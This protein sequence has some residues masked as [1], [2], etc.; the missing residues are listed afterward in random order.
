MAPNPRGIVAIPLCRRRALARGG[1]SLSAAAS[2][3][4]ARNFQLEP[5]PHGRAQTHLLYISSLDTRRLRT[6]DRADEG[7]HVL[8]QL[9][10]AE[11]HFAD[12][13]MADAGLLGTE[14]DLATLGRLDR[15]GDTLRHLA[16]IR[17]RHQAALLQQ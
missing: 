15:L 8:D 2:D 4:D 12:A 11:A 16:E 7:A 14:L 9:L 5:W 1:T 10:L 13:G 6:A 17:V 3:G